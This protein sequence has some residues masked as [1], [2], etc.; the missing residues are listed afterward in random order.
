MNH[1]Y[2]AWRLFTLRM[3]DAV[4]EFLE[5][6]PE[7]DPAPPELEGISLQEI[8]GG[9]YD[10]LYRVSGL[11]RTCNQAV[12]HFVSPE[13]TGDDLHRAFHCNCRG[14]NTEGYR[15]PRFTKGNLIDRPAFLSDVLAAQTPFK[16]FGFEHDSLAP[17]RNGEAS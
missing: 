6:C 4:S 7:R 16:S 17:Y 11:C 5:N 2:E 12:A 10:G 9:P 14:T 8:E 1:E 13:A 3:V 15:L